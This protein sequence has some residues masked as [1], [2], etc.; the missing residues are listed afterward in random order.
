MKLFSENVKISSFFK[1]K[2]ITSTTK[3]K[4]DLGRLF[5]RPVK[6]LSVLWKLFVRPLRTERENKKEKNAN[7]ET[8]CL[9]KNSENINPA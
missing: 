9:G 6:D 5:F 7:H 8:R 1:H 3:K 4:Q 2:N